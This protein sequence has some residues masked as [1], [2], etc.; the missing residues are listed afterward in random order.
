MNRIRFSLALLII[1][2]L[3]FTGWSV[4][5]QQTSAVPQVSVQ[6]SADGV[7]IPDELPE[8][9]VDIAFTN[10]T[11]APVAPIL[12][13][14]NPDVTIDAFNEALSQ[15]PMAAIPMVALLGGTE[16]APNTTKDIT[17]DFSVGTNVLLELN[18]EIP[19]VQFFNVADAEGEGA[20]APAADVQVTLMDFAFALPLEIAAGPQTWL[21]ENQGGQWH[22]MS[23]ARLPDDLTVTEFRDLVKQAAAGELDESEA[24]EMIF[25]APLSQGE[26]AWTTIDL[27]PGTYVVAC[28]LPDFASGHAHADMGMVQIITVTA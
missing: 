15:G 25:F 6:F 1:G 28:F 4:L 12:A 3:T 19:S 11:E 13:R 18:G 10:N 20:A 14:L 26:R 2:L 7:T 27:Q 9:V 17:F 16:I 8:G 24:G 21:L 5:A 22:E 23:I